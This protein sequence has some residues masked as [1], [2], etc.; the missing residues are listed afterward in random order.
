MNTFK[1]CLSCFAVIVAVW[2]T[3]VDDAHAGWLLNKNGKKTTE[4]KVVEQLADGRQ[5]DLKRLPWKTVD[6]LPD[7]LARKVALSRVGSTERQAY[8]DCKSALRAQSRY[9]KLVVLSTAIR[10]PKLG[11]QLRRLVDASSSVRAAVVFTPSEQSLF[12]SLTSTGRLP[13]GDGDMS[14]K[15][16]SAR[17]L[18]I[19]GLRCGSPS[20]STVAGLV[21]TTIELIGGVNAGRGFSD[22]VPQPKVY[23]VSQSASDDRALALALAVQPYLDATVEDLKFLF[24]EETKK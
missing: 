10:Y 24:P 9:S 23:N 15:I 20:A 11:S 22:L 1:R 17:N 13:A 14:R 19:E 12:L 8:D 4:D 21:R 18:V 6:T 16:C 3:A 2:L 5:A 7:G